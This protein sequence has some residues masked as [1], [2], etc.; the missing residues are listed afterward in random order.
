[1]RRILIIEDDKSIAE[2][3]KDYLIINNFEVDLEFD[4]KKGLEKALSN[5]YSLI[6]IDLMLPSLDG[7]KICKEIR[8][9]KDIPLVMV[10][11]KKSDIDKVRGFG[12]GLDDYLTKPFSPYELVARVK[13]H[14]SRYELLSSKKIGSSNNIIE[15]KGIV[16]NLIEHIV[17]VNG[18]ETTLTAK[19]F[20]LL[21]ILISNRGKVFSKQ[22]IFKKIWGFESEEDVPTITVHIRKLR[23]KI[24][25]NPAKPEYIKTV[26]GVGYKFEK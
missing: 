26:W 10:T 11:A 23:E 4:G 20:E 16:I 9:S 3:E 21:K 24:E 14:I 13:A 1:M 12:L 15:A 8:K 7:F 6:I 2:V 5:D 22:E 19:E 17:L 25:F 18:N